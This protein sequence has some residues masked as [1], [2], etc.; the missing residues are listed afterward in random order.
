[1]RSILCPTVIG[2]DEV[3]GKL[4]AAVAEG[5]SG[6]G[7]VTAVLG[8]AGIGKSRLVSEVADVGAG[9]GMR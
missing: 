4:E 7:G 8:E 3:L 6:R 1:M 5:R 2:R 9:R